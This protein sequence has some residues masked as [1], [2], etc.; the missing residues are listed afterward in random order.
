M[1]VEVLNRL[2]CCLSVV[3]NDI[4]TVCLKICDHLL[5]QLLCK[6]HGFACCFFGKLEEIGGMFL[7]KDKGVALG[8]GT[9]IEDHTEVV[10]FVDRL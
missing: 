10:I 8:G 4:E 5:T 7:G 2:A 1:K 3:L 9:E 6:L